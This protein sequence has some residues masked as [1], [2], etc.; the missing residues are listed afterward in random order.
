MNKKMPKYKKELRQVII[1]NINNTK[2]S[3]LL[4][5]LYIITDIMQRRSDDK[6]Y[7]TL[8]EEEWAISSIIINILPSNLNQLSV[9]QR[10]IS[11]FIT[12]AQ[13]GGSGYIP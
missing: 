5:D 7:E 11:S 9:I 2:N 8:T 13:M 3:V 12:K 1:E 10:F 6:A 4:K